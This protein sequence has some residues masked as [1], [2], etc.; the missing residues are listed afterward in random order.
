MADLTQY[1]DQGINAATSAR[2]AVGWNWAD[3]WKNFA[4][5][6]ALAAQQNDWNK[7]NTLEMWNLMN[8]YNTPSAQMTRF[9]E[10]GLNP[11][12]I[13]GQGTPGNASLPSVPAAA[14]VNAQITPSQDTARKIG[15][16]NEMIGMVSNVA[17][18][19]ASIMDQGLN[20]QLKKN[21]LVQSNF[22]TGALEHTF[23]KPGSTGINMVNL[24][25]T[26]NPL[27]S[28]FDPLAFVAFSQQGKLPGFINQ[29]MTDDLRRLGIEASTELTRFKSKYQDYYNKNLLP[30]FNEFQQ[31]KISLQDIEKELKNYEKTSLEMI[32]P[33]LRGILEPLI[34]Y[35]SPFI[36]FIFKRSS[37]TFNS[38]ST[39]TVTH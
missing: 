34:G 29:Y 7:Q 4:T 10:A 16:A 32:P 19:I 3:S 25:E 9:K 20:L 2:S 15:M 5:Q 23:G 28:K 35:I 18:N 17:T 31:G 26:L 1:M 21:E 12:L 6:Y 13:Y 24:D 14:G 33:E 37:G 8:E 22:E 27:S 11:M 30:K 39:H 36:K 38:H